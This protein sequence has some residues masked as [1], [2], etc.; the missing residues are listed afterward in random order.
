MKEDGTP[1]KNVMIVAAGDKHSVALTRDG[2]IY[3]WGDNT[4]GQLG[5]GKS[6]SALAYSTKPV[7]VAGENNSST[8]LSE[9]LAEK[10]EKISNIVS[11]RNHTLAVSNQGILYSWGANE[12]GQLGINT[13][14]NRY[15]PVQ[16]KGENGGDFLIDVILIGAGADHS[17]AVRTNGTVWSWGNNK[18]GQLGQGKNGPNNTYKNMLS[19]AKVS[20]GEYDSGNEDDKYIK[21]VDALSAGENFTVV[22]TREFSSAP[23][24]G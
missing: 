20:K 9:M 17:I 13:D 14:T 6:G 23:L 11:G 19:P 18:Y 2:V 3:T 12:S 1:L 24:S 22:T 21:N 10:N 15:F 16:V 4:Y 8:S 5:S 7:T